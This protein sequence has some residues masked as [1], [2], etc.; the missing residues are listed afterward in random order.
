MYCS[1]SVHLQRK[2]T[3]HVILLLITMAAYAKTIKVLEIMLK[4]HGTHRKL[5]LKKSE[6]GLELI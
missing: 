5:V 4:G 6:I 3:L 1:V 2:P